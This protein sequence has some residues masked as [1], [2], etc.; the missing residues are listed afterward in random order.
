MPMT[1]SVK[2]KRVMSKRVTIK[3]VVKPQSATW[4]LTL[5]ETTNCRPY[6]TWSDKAWRQ[7]CDS[8]ADCA[9][10]FSGI[11]LDKPADDSLRLA[12]WFFFVDLVHGNVAKPI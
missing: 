2:I 4:A 8:A 9:D 7:S 12:P 10:L 6:T 5:A 1:I 11:A 3:P